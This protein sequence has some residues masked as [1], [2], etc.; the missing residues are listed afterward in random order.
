MLISQ[1]CCL[2]KTLQLQSPGLTVLTA[3]PQLNTNAELRMTRFC[4][5]WLVACPGCF[6]VT[7]HPG[8]RH[9]PRCVRRCG[10][11][12]G[13]SRGAGSNSTRVSRRPAGRPST[14]ACAAAV[15]VRLLSLPHASRGASSA[16]C[17][18][19]CMV[20]VAAAMSTSPRAHSACAAVICTHLG[21]SLRGLP[22]DTVCTK[23]ATL[24]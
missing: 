2:L 20:Q 5:G 12:G 6:R 24:V 8:N 4:H 21:M 19:C 1:V 15:P 16:V 9:S 11:G 10:C 17:T 13:S 18:C 7:L 23:C 14:D 22:D 3:R